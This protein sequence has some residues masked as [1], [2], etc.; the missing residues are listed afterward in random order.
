MGTG[1]EPY[2]EDSKPH[3]A[4]SGAVPVYTPEKLA[5][6]F[7][8]LYEKLAPKYGYKTRDESAVPWEDV[9]EKNKQLMIRVCQYILRGV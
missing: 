9:P 5:E 2:T 3:E 8:T 4:N 7:H 6:R 1:H